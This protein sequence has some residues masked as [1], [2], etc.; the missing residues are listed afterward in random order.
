[1]CIRDRFIIDCG[2]AFP[3]SELPGVDSVIPDFTFVEENA[4]KIKGLILT[5]GHEDHIGGIP[6]LLKKI[7]VRCV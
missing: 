2:L 4:D 5:H 1:M 7:N 3:G 6:Y